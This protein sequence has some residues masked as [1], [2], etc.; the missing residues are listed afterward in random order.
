V[1]HEATGEQLGEARV[2]RAR[3][4]VDEPGVSHVDVDHRQIAVEL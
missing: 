4:G 2:E 1:A 3:Q